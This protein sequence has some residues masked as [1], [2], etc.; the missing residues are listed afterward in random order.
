[1]RKLRRKEA[2]QDK[3]DQIRTGLL[4]P[5]SPK[6]KHLFMIDRQPV[7]HVPSIYSATGQSYENSDV[8]CRPRTQVEAHVAQRKH[9]HE[10]MDAER[11]LTDEQG[12]EKL[13]A[14]KE[15]EEKKVI[16]SAVYKYFLFFFP[17][18]TDN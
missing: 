7:H 11:K 1:M 4:P 9:R 17:F 15:D 18:I 16:Y 8:G 14:K 10:E 13:E 3:R 12:R 6:G 2:L 5:D